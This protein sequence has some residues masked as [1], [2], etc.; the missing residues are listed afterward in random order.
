MISVSIVIQSL[1][2]ENNA[3]CSSNTTSTGA[4][5]ITRSYFGTGNKRVMYKFGCSGNEPSLQS[6]PKSTFSSQVEHWYNHGR[7]AVEC[8]AKGVDLTSEN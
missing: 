5:A 8:Q 3:M 6:C 4:V 2:L 7:D 1:L